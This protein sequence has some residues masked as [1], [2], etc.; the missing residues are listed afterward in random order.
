M[1]DATLELDAD[2]ADLPKGEWLTRLATTTDAHGFFQPLGRKHFAAMVQRG[3]T[4]LV[5]F[6][7]IQGMRALSPEAEPVGW[8]MVRDHGWSHLCIAS[9]GDTWFRDRH[10]IGLFDRMIDDGYFDDFETILFYGAGPCGYAAAAYSVAAP[11]ARVL[12]IQPQATLDPRV[13]E[14]DDRFVEMRRT[15]FTSRYG[16]A[17]DMLDAS[18]AAYVLYDPVETL[19]AMHA[20]LFVRSGV[21]QF[22]LRNM[23]DALQSDLMKMDILP[24]LIEQ[25]MAGTLNDMVFA[26]AYRARRTYPPYL[27]RV[28]AALDSAERTDLTYMVARNV[29]ARMKAPRF[30]R[31]L[32]E[33]E[34]LRKMD[35]ENP[36][37]AAHGD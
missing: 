15:D 11:G 19:D 33:I 22:R 23:G 9:D 30:Q 29:T 34:A 16:F 37:E 3:D 8:Q 27:R 18:A 36:D 7:T 14:W 1:Q 4:L 31:R 2:L 24:E 32:S 21:T 10:V 13:T 26:N 25:A 12:A 5:T 17:P 6:E 28:M 20:A 35:A